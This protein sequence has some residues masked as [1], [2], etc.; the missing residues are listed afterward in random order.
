MTVLLFLCHKR[1]KNTLS[2]ISRMKSV[3]PKKFTSGALLIMTEVWRDSHQLLEVVL[4][5]VG[6]NHHA[7]GYQRV[8]GKVEDLVAEEWNDPSCMLLRRTDGG[9]KRRHMVSN[10]A[11]MFS[12]FVCVVYLFTLYAPY[13]AMPH[14]RIMSRDIAVAMQISAERKH[15]WREDRLSQLISRRAANASFHQN[16]RFFMGIH[17]CNPKVSRRPNTLND[18]T[19]LSTQSVVDQ[20][21]ISTWAIVMQE[22]LNLI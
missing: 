7:N 2:P 6:I 4:H 3:S 21:I 17:W 5:R 12:L 10:K 15:T 11:R 9:G 8:K 13:V 20:N 18:P 16:P 14:I 22:V 1:G 19:I